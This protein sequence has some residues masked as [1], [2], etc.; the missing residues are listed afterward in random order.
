MYGRSKKDDIN[1]WNEIEYQIEANLDNQDVYKKAT[2]YL[3]KFTS[4]KHNEK[5]KY[6]TI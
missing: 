6:L 4:T 1:K 3:E 5:I 2:K